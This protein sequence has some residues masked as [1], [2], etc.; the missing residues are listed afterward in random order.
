MLFCVSLHCNWQWRFT[1]HCLEIS[2]FSS[3]S[4][5]FVYG[6]VQ[7]KKSQYLHIYYEMK[8]DKCRNIRC[9][10]KTLFW[11]L[12]KI[13]EKRLWK[14]YFFRKL[15]YLSLPFQKKKHCCSCFVS[16]YKLFRLAILQNVCKWQLLEYIDRQKS[17]IL[18]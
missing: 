12:R 14:V 16:F 15:S 9:S 17:C 2:V 8:Y 6:K 13:Y 10:V 11:Q 7:Y 3:P 18:V 1:A 5:Q 4:I